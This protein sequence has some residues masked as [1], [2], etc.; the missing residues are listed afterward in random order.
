MSDE[1]TAAIEQSIADATGG[2]NGDGATGD[3]GDGGDS[4]TENEATSGDEGTDSGTGSDGTGSGDPGSGDG[5][6]GT[7]SQTS[8]DGDGQ[9]KGKRPRHVKYEDH[10]RTIET[11]KKEFGDKLS[12]KDKELEAVAWAKDPEAQAIIEAFTLAETEP[13]KFAAL[14][15]KDTKIATALRKQLG[16]TKAEAKELATNLGTQTPR[17][18]DGRPKPNA[19]TKDADGNEIAYYDN[20]GLA[21]LIDW[22]RDSASE[23]AY[24]RFVKDFGPIAD[25]IKA[26]DVANEALARN[27]QRL[28][29]YRETWDGFKENEKEIT[30]LYLKDKSLTLHDAH[31]LVMTRI[32]KA[33]L[34]ERDKLREKHRQEFLAE[35]AE[36]RGASA[37]R[38]E[39]AP[40]GGGSTGSGDPIT[41]AINRSIRK[42]GLV[43]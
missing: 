21:A 38:S 17:D 26:N 35:Q 32:R 12:A 23:S 10:Q 4:G 6:D 36:K 34:A 39:T 14:I 16:V 15:V 20:D 43:K 7:E 8:G 18:A 33:E 22:A 9:P 31:R 5:G 37:D 24:E 13:D 28:E 40:V 30:D 42:A 25:R 41:D 11:I 3:L 1:I 29:Q 27:R 19:R 2:D